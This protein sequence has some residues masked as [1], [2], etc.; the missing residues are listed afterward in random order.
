MA[1]IGTKTIESMVHMIAGLLENYQQELTDAY[2]KSE[3]V[4]SISIG[5][6]VKPDP[7]GNAIKTSLS[8]TKEK[9]QAEAESIVDDEQISLF[10][11]NVAEEEEEPEDTSDDDMIMKIASER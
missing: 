10:I 1:G 3:G 11:G 4:F 6:K 5:V 8:F 9:I 2:L 7:K